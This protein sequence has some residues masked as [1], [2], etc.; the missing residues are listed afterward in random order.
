M[1]ST[2]FHR[3]INDNFL[4]EAAGVLGELCAAYPKESR[5]N[6]VKVAAIACMAITTVIVVLR[7]F[8]RLTVTSRLWWDDL[9]ILLATVRV[10]F[11]YT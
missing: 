4:S 5:S 10:F 8:A 3:N 9:T 7:S 11:R 6:E 1:E 2:E